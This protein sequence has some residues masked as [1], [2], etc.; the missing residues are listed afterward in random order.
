MVTPP[1]D[2]AFPKL[3]RLTTEGQFKRV[4]AH[5]TSAANSVIVVYGA[6]NGLPFCR[7]GLVVSRKIG[8]AV[9]RNRWKRLIREA[10]RQQHKQLPTGLDLVVLPRAGSEPNCE[11]VS[12]ALAKL[13]GQVA[14]RLDHKAASVRN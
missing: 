10:F 7:L 14:R 4:F 5:R 13:V 3:H 2:A 8:G 1:V 9:V 11:T 12:A 6:P